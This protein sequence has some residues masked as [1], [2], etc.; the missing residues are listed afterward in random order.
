MLDLPR[1]LRSQD[2]G[3][4]SRCIRR[5]NVVTAEKCARFC[6]G[7]AESVSALVQTG[8]CLGI[9]H[10]SAP[11]SATTASATI[12][13]GRD[14]S[15]ASA[16][17]SSVHPS[18]AVSAGRRRSRASIT[19]MTTSSRCK[20]PPQHQWRPW[21]RSCA[22]VRWGDHGFMPESASW[23]GG[24]CTISAYQQ[25]SRRWAHAVPHSGGVFVRHSSEICGAPCELPERPAQH[26]DNRHCAR[27][28]AD[29]HH[30]HATTTTPVCSEAGQQTNTF[31]L[32]TC[33]YVAD[34]GGVGSVPMP[35]WQR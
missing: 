27:R 21:P 15:A 12:S 19:A 11:S 34:V 26:T 13:S 24:A 29:K 17:A 30:R 28:R 14:G 16:A 31:Q 10:A 22:R 8:Q 3:T 20:P 18:A 2:T 23:C 1:L 32:N 5:R 25:H 4:C 35:M 6:A 33:Q 9:S 7:H